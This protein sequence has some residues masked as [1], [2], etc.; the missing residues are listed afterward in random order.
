MLFDGFV[1]MRRSFF[2]GHHSAHLA[3][4]RLMDVKLSRNKK[5]PNLLNS[6]V[7]WLIVDSDG[8]NVVQIW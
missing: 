3:A 1:F 5:K 2:V 7:N 8:S 4:L 6:S